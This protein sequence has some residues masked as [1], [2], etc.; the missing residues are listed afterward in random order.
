MLWVCGIALDRCGAFSSIRRYVTGSRLKPFEWMGKLTP[1][2]LLVCCLHSWNSP[3]LQ[4]PQPRPPAP[5][6]VPSGH[7]LHPPT[8]SP[9]PRPY[10]VVQA[11]PTK[12]Y[13]RP[14]FPCPNGSLVPLAVGAAQPRTWR[15]GRSLA[16]RRLRG[17][18]QKFLP[19]G[20]SLARFS[21]SK[22]GPFSF[23][24]FAVPEC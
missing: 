16:S 18:R 6:I 22:P 15:R 2:N 5:P 7:R 20:R 11:R 12:S 10:H 23:F 4:L 1:N 17:A 3:S 21:S 13:S 19:D 8:P 24:F 14:P 9:H